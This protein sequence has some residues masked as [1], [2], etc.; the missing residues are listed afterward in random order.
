[1]LYVIVK[2]NSWSFYKYIYGKCSEISNI[3][4]LTLCILMDSSFWFD[5]MN[6][7]KVHCTYLGVSGYNFLKKNVFCLKFC[8]TLTNSVDP[9]AMQHYAV[10]HQGLHC[11]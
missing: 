3:L 9:D 6:L 8:F 10:F 1:M 4:F 7:G 5:T 2:C 11:L